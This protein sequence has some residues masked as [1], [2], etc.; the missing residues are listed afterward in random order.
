MPRKAPLQHLLLDKHAITVDVTN[1]SSILV[2]LINMDLYT[3][4]L[5]KIHQLNLGLLSI[6]HFQLRCINSPHSNAVFP[7]KDLSVVRTLYYLVSI[8]IDGDTR[9][10]IHA[11]VSSFLRPRIQSIMHF[12]WHLC[13]LPGICRVDKSS[14]AIAISNTTFF[15]R[16]SVEDKLHALRHRRW[17][18]GDALRVL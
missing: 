2:L 5:D 9:K 17:V 14:E 3:F 11:L 18:M 10:S 7:S 8:P 13:S 12:L 4:L 16:Q 1:V 6:L 15:D